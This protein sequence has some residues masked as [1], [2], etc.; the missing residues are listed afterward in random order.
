L[1]SLNE[2]KAVILNALPLTLGKPEVI[3][4]TFDRQPYYPIGAFEKNSS[5]ASNSQG[6]SLSKLD[7]FI[8]QSYS[9]DRFSELC[10][11][12]HAG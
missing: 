2:R 12:Q 6:F 4:I 9:H 3:G 5:R 8:L 1:E 11:R 7:Y 10:Q